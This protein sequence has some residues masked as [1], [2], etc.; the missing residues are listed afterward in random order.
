MT[1]DQDTKPMPHYLTFNPMYG[2]EEIESQ[3]RFYPENYLDAEFR[4]ANIQHDEFMDDVSNWRSIFRDIPGK[5][6]RIHK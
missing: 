1:Y 2:I 6:E 3:N 4:A 5:L